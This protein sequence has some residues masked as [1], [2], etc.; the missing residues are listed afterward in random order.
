MSRGPIRSRWSGFG[1]TRDTR[2]HSVTLERYLTAEALSPVCPDN[3]IG[4][5]LDRKVR[6]N[7]RSQLGK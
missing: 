6:V 7:Y 2:L 5:R 1:V 4:P 3:A